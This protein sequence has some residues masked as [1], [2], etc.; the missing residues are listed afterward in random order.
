MIAPSCFDPRAML[1]NSIKKTVVQFTAGFLTL[2][3]ATSCATRSSNVSAAYVSPI[4]YSHLSCSQLRQELAR[5]NAKVAEVS[6]AQD[7]A[8]TRDAVAT[9]VG[10]VI[11]WPALFFLMA[12]DQKQ[13]LARL[14]GE[15]DALV[16]AGIQKNCGWAK[17]MRAAETQPRN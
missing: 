1:A 17:D 2:C 11:F 4:T 14:K 12:G 3:L 16:S 13:E 6:G 5:V 7:R 9:G 15:Y 8:A 10:L